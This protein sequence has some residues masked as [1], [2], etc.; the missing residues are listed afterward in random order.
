MSYFHVVIF[1]EVILINQRSPKFVVIDDK[2]DLDEGPGYY[3]PAVSISSRLYSSFSDPL[4]KIKIALV[5]VVVLWL[6]KT[7]SKLSSRAN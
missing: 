3:L 5:C 7:S 2:N 6:H 1:F 4:T